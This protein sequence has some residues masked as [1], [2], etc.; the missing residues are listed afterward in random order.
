[1]A[2]SS[3]KPHTSHVWLNEI[4]SRAGLAGILHSIYRWTN[5]AS[6]LAFDYRVCNMDP[7]ILRKIHACTDT[8]CKHVYV[9]MGSF[10]EF[11]ADLNDTAGHTENVQIH[12][13]NATLMHL[14][15]RQRVSSI[16]NRQWTTYRSVVIKGERYTISIL[17]KSI[18]IELFCGKREEIKSMRCFTKHPYILDSPSM[19]NLTIPQSQ[20][21]FLRLTIVY[22]HWHTKQHT[23]NS[24]R[25]HGELIQAVYVRA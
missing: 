9:Y 25:D 24:L 11:P 7:A 3:H 15:L 10:T 16:A 12:D 5:K 17:D 20:H 4:N 6:Q 18:T 22:H 13:Q 8:S 2:S 1:M 14:M 23:E 19:I 21:S